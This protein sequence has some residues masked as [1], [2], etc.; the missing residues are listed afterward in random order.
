MTT[1]SVARV[2]KPPRWVGRVPMGQKS[3]YSSLL[4]LK[5]R[6]HLG[7]SAFYNIDAPEQALGWLPLGLGLVEDSDQAI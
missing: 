2:H 4:G 3:F 6:L 7:G 5:A 1:Y